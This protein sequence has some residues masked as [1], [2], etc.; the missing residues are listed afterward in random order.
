[1]V[2]PVAVLATGGI[3]G[4]SR[5]IRASML[6]VVNQD[7]IRTAKSKGL[8]NRRVWF[9]HAARNALIP[10]ATFLGPAIFG[11]IGGAVI[12]ETLFSWPG[13]GRLSITAVNNLDMPLLMAITMIGAVQTICGFI[14]SDILYA[15]F[16]P[17][18]RFG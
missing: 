10:M 18:I 12:T 2:L 13:L 16:D 1:M 8:P 5:Y 4:F 3:A 17:R 11:L 15:A 7:Y 9:I 6:D 14:L